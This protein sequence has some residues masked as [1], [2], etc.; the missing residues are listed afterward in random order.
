M[1]V[2]TVAL[3]TSRVFTQSDASPTYAGN[4]EYDLYNS[5][6]Q[7]NNNN[8]SAIRLIVD[9]EAATPISV[10][11]NF[12]LIALLEGSNGEGAPDDRWFTL[13]NQFEPFRRD[14]AGKRRVLVT[15]QQVQDAEGVDHIVFLGFP[16]ERKSRE[17]GKGAAKWRVRLVL[18]EFGAGTAGEFTDVTVSMYAELFD[19]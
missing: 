6:V 2:E 18:R 3:E 17:N 11:R 19:G 13:V 8:L 9:Y 16:R 10:D 7:N 5:G 14:N 4:G 12:D 15:G 1:P